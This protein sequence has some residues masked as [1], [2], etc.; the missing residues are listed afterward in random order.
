M[1]ERIRTRVFCQRDNSV[2]AIELE[3]PTTKKRFWSFPGGAIEHLESPEEA[4]VRETLEET[5]YQVRLVSEPYV[6][7][8]LFR[9]DARIYQCKTYWYMAQLNFE[10]PAPVDDAAYL[11]GAAWL[12]WPDSRNLFIYNPALTEA[13]DRFMPI[14]SSIMTPG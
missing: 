12:P 2:L 8:Y 10:E 9:W 11:L 7:E 1:I 13:V 6:N 3:D 14:P 4:A 5:G